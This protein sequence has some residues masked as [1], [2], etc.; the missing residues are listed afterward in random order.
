MK[1]VSFFQ[2]LVMGIFAVGGL[3]G[4]FVFSTYKGSSSETTV[5]PV[6]IWGALPAARFNAL[7][8]SVNRLDQSLESVTYVEQSSAQFA[9]DL[10]AAIA[11]GRGPDLVLFSHE[12]LLSLAPFIQPIPFSTLPERTLADSYIEESGL[13]K[14]TNGFY[15]VPFLLDPL[16]LFHNRTILASAGIPTPPSTW[17]ALTGLVPKVTTLTPDGRLTRSLAALGTYDNIQN[18]RGILSALFL[19]TNVPISTVSQSGR[20]EVE[21]MRSSAASGSSSGEAVLRFYTQFADSS[22]LSYTWD[23]SR[24]NS[25]NAF[26][27]G[28]LA[29]YLGFASEAAGLRDANPNLNFDVAPLPQPATATNKGTYGLLYALA[30]PTGAKNPT[31]ALSIASLLIQKDRQ[32][33]AAQTFGLAPAARTAIAAGSADPTLAVAYS[34]ALYAKGW[35]SPAPRSVDQVFSGM[36]NNVISGRLS[37]QSALSAAENALSALLQ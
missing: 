36:I 1:N 35:L 11:T 28:D 37:I 2:V 14:T 18:A 13:L 26:L 34:S 27:R 23:A 7:A 22:K 30:I 12:D 4:L 9:T 31:G 17:E 15:G 5:G 24:E 32:Q 20:R 16:V 25:R 33:I 21:L 8:A 6:T 19:Q 29:I 3:I 10:A